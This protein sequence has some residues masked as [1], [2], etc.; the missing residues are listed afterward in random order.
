M[1]Y[2][3]AWWD[4]VKAKETALAQIEAG[5]DVIYSERYGAFEAARDKKVYAFGN[6][7]DMHDLAPETIISS[8]L[9]YWDPS[10]KQMIELWYNNKVNG[11]AYNAPADKPVFFLM[12]DGGSA[13]APLYQFEKTLPK[14]TLDKFN[15]TKTKIINGSLQVEL[16]L[17]SLKSD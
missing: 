8:P 4:P 13:V 17:K 1:A 9:M 15:E 5:A 2:I 3:E 10:I 11:T 16:K 7:A 14:A 6:Q 12:K